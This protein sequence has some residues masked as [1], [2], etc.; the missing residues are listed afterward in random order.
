M[1]WKLVIIAALALAAPEVRVNWTRGGQSKAIRISIDNYDRRLLEECIQGGLEVRYVYEMRLCHK[2][3][4]WLDRCGQGRRETRSVQHDP[5]SQTYRVAT[6]R[7]GDRLP[8][9][10]ASMTSLEQVFSNISQIDELPLDV[11]NGEEH[12]VAV[13]APS[14]VAVRVISECQG[15]YSETLQQISYFLSLGLVRTSGF[16]SG[17]I[18]FQ[19]DR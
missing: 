11:F 8:P 19:L 15:Q 7:L 4:Y 13:Q 9:K 17:W 14:Y 16:D 10:V 6:D 12:P 5:I 3:W 1:F 18:S 2:R